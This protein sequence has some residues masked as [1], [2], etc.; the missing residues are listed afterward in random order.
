MRKRR[1]RIY[2]T[3]AA[4][5]GSFQFG[6]RLTIVQGKQF[7][8]VP[9][10]KRVPPKMLPASSAS[11]RSL[12]YDD[13][14][15]RDSHLC[16]TIRSHRTRMRY[17]SSLVAA[18]NLLASVVGYFALSHDDPK[19]TPLFCEG[20]KIVLC[21]ISLAQV[22]GI[23]DYWR[24][25]CILKAAQRSALR[26]DYVSTKGLMGERGERNKCYLE[27]GLHLLVPFPFL[28]IYERLTLFGAAETYSLSDLLYLSIICRNYHLLRV[29]YWFSRFS[30]MRTLMY[31]RITTVRSVN[32]FIL[33]CL[34]AQYSHKLVVSMYALIV[35]FAGLAQ[36]TLEQYSSEPD[37]PL[38]AD[39]FW[40]VSYT[41]AT[42]GYGVDIPV[43]FFGQFALIFTIVSGII[44]MGVLT[45]VSGDGVALSFKEFRMC[46]A[47]LTHWYK[48]RKLV[49][50]VLVIQAWWRLIKSRMRKQPHAPT[51]LY[52]YYYLRKYRVVLVHCNSIKAGLFQNQ[53]AAF[54]ASVR[55]HIRRSSEYLY[56]IHH[57]AELVP[58]TQT[59]D[60]ER[61]EYRLAMMA[62]KIKKMTKKYDGGR[63]P[64]DLSSFAVT[65]EETES[66]TSAKS[67][68][69]R[70][71]RQ[72]TRTFIR[73]KHIAMQNV[74]TR[75]VRRKSRITDDR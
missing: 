3:K 1:N 33:R 26:V 18:L 64:R 60:I 13:P 57:A 44:L 65:T 56:A 68:T 58:L 8:E 39:S 47:L 55:S 61:T 48:K 66:P 50:A 63:I 41:Q 21:I 67:R 12:H 10:L 28:N 37:R 2:H 29:L 42:I 35:L 22:V 25:G 62:R 43:T 71:A 16:A 20:L 32:G 34:L 30:S 69:G 7:S 24:V 17:L 38:V 31:A 72:S 36:Y 52:F 74:K 73:A 46:S 5:A 70:I 9:L 19:H 27:C 45:T 11:S 53:L 4:P 51:I 54:E 14:S 49:S 15:K 75:L 6:K 23:V 59:H 40:I